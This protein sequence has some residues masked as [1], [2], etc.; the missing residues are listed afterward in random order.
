MVMIKSVFGKTILDSRKDKTIEVHIKTNA[1]SFYASAPNGKSKG[2]KEARS[3]KKDI[4]GDISTLK[5]F[6]D[7]FSAENID[8]FDDLKRIEDILDGNVGADTFVAFEYAILKALAKEKK[9][10]I[11][12]LINPK[13]RKLPR[14]LGNCVG[15]GKHSHS[16]RKPDFQEFLLVPKTKSVKKAFELNKKLREKIKLELKIKDNKFKG[17]ISDENAWQTQLN[18]K[19][20]LDII[21][22]FGV[23]TG[24]DIAASGFYKRKKYN[25]KNPL[26]KRTPEEQF[27]HVS[28]LI[29]NTNIFYIEDA[30]EEEDFESFAK[31]LK[32]FPDRLIVGD[33]LTVTN[34]KRFEKALKKK[35]I[36]AIIV[37]PNQ[38]GPL[39][40]VKRVCELAKK[41]KIKICFSHRSGETIE[42]TLADLAFGFGADFFKCG[43]VGAERESKL[44][45]LIE[46]ERKL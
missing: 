34:V 41:N 21:S 3:Y 4:E 1:G 31:L 28:N 2:K 7:Y 14:L 40:E 43:I 22:D 5:K 35:S 9:K 37:K 17:E 19:Q 45:R 27:V 38:I 33:D 26:L 39:T 44:K 15:G 6:S 10:E 20:V 16:D 42:N 32:K 46:I 24:L 25:Y 13:A 11:W 12:Q 36:N 23:S 29:K 8:K 18:E 30:F